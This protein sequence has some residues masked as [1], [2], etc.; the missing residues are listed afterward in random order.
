[1]LDK[2]KTTGV[3][4]LPYARVE[5]RDSEAWVFFK[6]PR[7]LN[8]ED[9]N[10]VTDAEICVDLALLDSASE[11]CVTRGDVIDQAKCHFSDALIRN[12]EKF[13]DAEKRKI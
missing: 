7:Y 11:V 12:L 4:G 3:V 6:N 13:W 2:F 5:H 10:T 1:M 8:A 9:D